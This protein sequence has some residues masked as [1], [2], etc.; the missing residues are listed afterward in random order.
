MVSI[1]GSDAAYEERDDAGQ[2]R[3]LDLAGVVVPTPDTPIHYQL[4]TGV[5]V[6]EEWMNA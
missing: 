5:E 1:L 4:R 2:V 6:F 3:F